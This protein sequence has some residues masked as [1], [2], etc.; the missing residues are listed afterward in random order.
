MPISA[1][2]LTA[3]DAHQ[4]VDFSSYSAG[5]DDAEAELKTDFDARVTM[6]NE[7][8]IACSVLMPSYDYDK[9]LGLESTARVAAGIMQ[10][11]SWAP[12]LFPWIGCTVEPQHYDAAVDQLSSFLTQGKFRI[13]S[14]HN[15]YQGLSVDAPIMY[16]LIEVAAQNQCVVVLHGTGNLDHEE[17]WRIVRVVKAFP[18]TSF[19]VLDT[20]MTNASIQV[21]IDLMNEADNVWIDTAGATS[22]V[23]LVRQAS[24]SIGC[25]RILF[26]SDYY[27]EG[28]GGIANLMRQQLDLCEWD[29]EGLQQVM[30]DN[31]LQLLGPPPGFPS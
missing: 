12:D 13:A 1:L 25:R 7:A 22:F 19:V 27:G 4:H 24:N 30:Q 23:H 18:A 10:Y 31:L 16:K 2:E 28:R 15:R 11:Q 3:F 6:M 8:N 29:A 21:M 26:G 17:A 5:R 14:W 9:R 20:L